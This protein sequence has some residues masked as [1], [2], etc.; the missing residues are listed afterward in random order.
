MTGVQTC[1]LPIC[2][3]ADRGNF[4]RADNLHLT[5]AFL[6][7]TD[8]DRIP[9]IKAAMAAVTTE[10]FPLVFSDVGCFHG[11]GGHGRRPGDIWWLGTEECPS[12]LHLVQE[13]TTSLRQFGFQIENRPFIS[14]LTI[15]RSIRLIEDPQIH[16][17]RFLVA[18]EQIS[19]MQ[20]H[21]FEGLL[22]YTSLFDKTLEAKD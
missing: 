14:H 3:V 13:L 16:Y 9:I 19:L 21:S 20:S 5:L 1:A 11:R 4:T 8:P 22:T 2:K 18:V 17:D 10:A 6:G 12:L 15:A 7:E